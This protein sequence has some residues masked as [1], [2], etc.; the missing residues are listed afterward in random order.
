MVAARSA[1]ESG[2]SSTAPPFSPAG[3]APLT[4]LA[5]TVWKSDMTD[6][7]SAAPEIPRRSAL[8]LAYAQSAGI[9]LS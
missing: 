5:N 9:A 8:R 1:F 2:E 7:A 6:D 3:V 4:T